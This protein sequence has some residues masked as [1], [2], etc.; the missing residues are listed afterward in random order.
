M[1]LQVF[2]EGIGLGVLLILVCAIGIRKSA[3]GMV[4]LYSSEVQDRCV[5][6]GLTTHEKIKRNALIF[7]AVCVPGYIAYVLVCVYMVNGT[8]DFLTGFWQL[9]IIL[10]VMNLMDR[11]LV[12]ELWVGHTNAWTIPGTED[13]KPYITIKDKAKK[14][15]FGTVGMAVISAALAAIMMLFMES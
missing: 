12:D 7:K 13:L 5:K 6:L 4:H 15:L 9:L 3:V 11:F 14:W 2:L 1:I 10:S 8:R